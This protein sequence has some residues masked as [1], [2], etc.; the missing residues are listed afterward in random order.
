VP[1]ATHAPPIRQLL[2]SVTLVHASA[3]SSQMSTVH[4]SASAQSRGIEAQV[5]APSHAS[6]TVQ[7]APSVQAAPIARGEYP[8]VETAEMHAA[9][10]FVGSSAPSAMQAPP[11]THPPPIAATHASPA[12]SQLS[13]VQASP[14][15]QLRATP[16]QPPA[17]SH[18][19]I[20]V[21]NAPS[22]HAAPAPTGE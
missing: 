15:S 22:S 13:V 17:P 14:S 4:A 5:P 7:N 10:S 18:A 20:T 1:P 2:A 21:Q 9:H 6:I 12:S 16:P 11:I 19:S 8:V 3:V